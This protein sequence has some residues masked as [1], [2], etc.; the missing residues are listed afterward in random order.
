MPICHKQRF[1][2]KLFVLEKTIEINSVTFLD[3]AFKYTGVFGVYLQRSLLTSILGSSRIA[4]KKSP[5]AESKIVG[6]RIGFEG[7]RT[8]WETA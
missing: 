8:V 3:L 7:T 4:S 2:R 5:T 6:F 1:G